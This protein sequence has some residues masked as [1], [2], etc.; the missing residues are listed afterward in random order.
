MGDNDLVLSSAL[1]DV[2]AAWQPALE[3]P[4]LT[5]EQEHDL[6]LRMHDGHP[7]AR[8]QLLEHNTR[9]VIWRVREK[10]KQNEHLDASELAQEGM[11]GL[12]RAVELFDPHLGTKLST[13][14]TRWI[15]Q[16]IDRYI[17]RETARGTRVPIDLVGRLRVALRD[18]RYTTDDDV[19]DAVGLTVDE[20]REAMG[21]IKPLSLNRV[22]GGTDERSLELHELLPSTTESDPAQT[23]VDELAASQ[24]VHGL[25][26]VLRDDELRVIELRYGL[27][28]RGD[29][30]ILETAG[31]LGI[32]EDT[33]RMLERR[34]IHRM[35][36]DQDAPE[37]TTREATTSTKAAPAVA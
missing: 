12:I 29:R 25:I 1:K 6:F 21:A 15:D 27:D 31:E 3:L 34:A 30:T 26:S 32:R 33:V 20:L 19:A 22:A 8:R 7:G 24:R 17:I 10:L 14:A 35:R 36:G 16:S 4:L 23:Y 13:Y 18:P 37:T 28:G 11:K 9:L 5:R 2:C